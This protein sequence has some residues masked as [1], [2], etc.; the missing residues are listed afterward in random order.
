MSD[1]DYFRHTGQ[2]SRV[3][4][5]KYLFTKT[6]QEHVNEEASLRTEISRLEEEIGR[7]EKENRRLKG[8]QKKRLSPRNW[9][10][11]KRT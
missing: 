5:K 1:E 9:K 10:K 11:G 7:L 2:T 6:T 8:R 4:G 3:P